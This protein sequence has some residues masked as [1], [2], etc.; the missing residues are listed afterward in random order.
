VV[1]YRTPPPPPGRGARWAAIAVGVLG[2]GA[3]AAG[4]TTAVLSQRAADQVSSGGSPDMPVVFDGAL[5]DAESRSDTYRVIAY[6]GF[7]VAA[8]AAAGAIGLALLGRKIDRDAPRLTLA[9]TGGAGMVGAALAGTF[10]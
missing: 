8:A 4:I 2:A 5:R 6:V 9:P 3:L 7:G 10:W 1:V